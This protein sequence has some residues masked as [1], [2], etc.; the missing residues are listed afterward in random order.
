MRS[1]AIRDALIDEMV[2]SVA[3]AR[4]ALPLL[5]FAV[6]RLWEGR[7]RERKRLTREA[8]GAIGG[9]AGAL[10]HHA[11]GTLDR[12]GAERQGL[13]REIFRV[14]VTAHGTRA[15]ADREEL[16][17]AFPEGKAAEE[18]LGDLIDARLL[19]SFEVEGRAGEASHHRVEVVHE[20]LLS[21]WLSLLCRLATSVPAP[22]LHTVRYAGVLAAASPWRP[23]IAPKPP[24]EEPAAASAEPDRTGPAGGYRPKCH[25]RMRL[26]A[27]VEE[28]ANVARFLAAM[29]EATE[30]PRRSPGRGRPY[31]KSRVLRR[32]ALGDEDD[33]QG[34]WVP[35]TA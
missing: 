19:T 23:R 5:A 2:R 26:L 17:S 9:V 4:S 10:A 24:T 30:V 6:S 22:R 7:D 28:P 33:G 14:L 27:M 31:W 15:V 16:L 8:Y 18:V 35:H 1:R 20:L 3:G 12:I 34:R 32:Q 29:G 25:G 13:V 21:A 11:E